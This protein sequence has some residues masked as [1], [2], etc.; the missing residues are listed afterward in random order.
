[1]GDPIVHVIVLM[2]ENHSFDQMLG[3]LAGSIAGLDGVDLNQPRG[4][5]DYPDTTHMVSQQPT[6]LTSIPL[7]PAHEFADVQRQLENGNSGFIRDYV[8]ANPNCTDAEKQQIMGYYQDGFLPILHTLAKSFVVCDQWFSSLPGPTWPNRFFVHS[9]TSMGH[10]KMP[11][12]I[13]DPNWHCYDQTTLY[14]RLCEKGISWRIYH[15]GEAQSMVMVD[16]LLHLDHYSKME[17]F[18][19]DVQ[20][21]AN[22]PQ[23]VFIEPCYS[24]A[25]QNDQHPPSDIMK[26]ELLIAKVYNAI[27]SNEALWA[28]T[29]FVLL[30]D[31]HG[32]FY[33]HAVPPATVAPDE[34]TDEFAFNQL[35]LR[36]PAILASPWLDAQVDHTV[37]DHTSLLRYVSDKWGLGPLGARTAQANS[38]S[39]LL[40][41]RS[42]ARSDAPQPFQQALLSPAETQNKTINENQKALVGFS[43]YLE[44]HMEEVEDMAAVGT[45]TIR[46]LRG[47]QAQFAVAKDRFE[48]MI[49]R[50][51]DG[52][53]QPTVPSSTHTCPNGNGNAANS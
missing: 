1:M 38:F 22:F 26:G 31:E 10:V 29:L 15:D 53:I 30:Y 27:R 43:Q 14:D 34:H 4:I 36:V 19:D 8:T 20:V 40:E 7:D 42:A 16:Q 23:Y 46:M 25:G 11:N 28:N 6:T 9:G 48:S 18:F 35:G 32:G 51:K 13:F 24:G 39:A 52:T 5:P 37:Y 50:A 12:G 3:G 49:Q 33:D 2:M 45:R 41:K 47:P 21:Q 44:K 17:D